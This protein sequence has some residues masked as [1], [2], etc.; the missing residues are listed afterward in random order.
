PFDRA[1]HFGGAGRR[2][3][4]NCC[5]EQWWHEQSHELPEDMA[6][7]DERYKAQWMQPALILAVRRD[8]S[9]KRL[10]IGQKISVGENYAPRLGR[11]A[12]GEKDLRDVISCDGL[13]SQGLVHGH[14]QMAA[15]VGSR[16]GPGIPGSVGQIL[17]IQGSNGGV[18]DGFAR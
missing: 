16:G 8:P 18:K 9:L 13:V 2:L 5:P 11:G 1:N 6:K 15:I 14:G 7:R 17:Q 3:E 10:E 12:R 4:D